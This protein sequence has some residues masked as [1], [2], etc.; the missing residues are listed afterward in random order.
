[1]G[2]EEDINNIR[3]AVTSILE[4]QATME[5]KINDLNEKVDLLTIRKQV[6]RQDKE[7][8]IK[9]ALADGLCPH[10]ESNECEQCNRDTS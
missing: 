9:V 4:H 7:K 6:D 2:I 1:M 3:M 10:S 8:R 5:M